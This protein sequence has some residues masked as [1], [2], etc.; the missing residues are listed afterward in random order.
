[1]AD[2]IATMNETIDRTARGRLNTP[3]RLASDGCTELAKMQL[4]EWELTNREMGIPSAD[5]YDELASLR[6]A[7]WLQSDRENRR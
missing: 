7:E 3:K 4:K 5:G 2:R 6:V 1:M